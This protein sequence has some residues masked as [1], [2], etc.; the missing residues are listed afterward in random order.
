MRNKN[1]E[2]IKND[3]FLKDSGMWFWRTINYEITCCVPE[4]NKDDRLQEGGPPFSLSQAEVDRGGEITCAI[5]RLQPQHNIC[6]G[7]IGLYDV[8]FTS[9]FSN[10][11]YSVFI[12][13]FLLLYLLNNTESGSN[14][15]LYASWSVNARLKNGC[16][17]FLFVWRFVHIYAYLQLT[18]YSRMHP[19][20][21]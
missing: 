13:L 2:F 3:R 1:S 14:W 9:I 15:H 19:L 5:P 12:F 20:F 21:N 7:S 18:L 8:N 17:L 4:H 11:K 10:I 16:L 6:I